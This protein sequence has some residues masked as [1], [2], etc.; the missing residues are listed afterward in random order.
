MIRRIV[1]GVIVGSII[2]VFMFGV[3]HVLNGGGF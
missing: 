2:A 3:R 1:T